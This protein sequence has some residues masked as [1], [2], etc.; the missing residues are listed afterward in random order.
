MGVRRVLPSQNSR[1][2][3][4]AALSNRRNALLAKGVENLKGRIERMQKG[5]NP[6]FGDITW[7]AGGSTSE[8]TLELSK[9]MQ[10]DYGLVT[11]M[12]LTC[13]NMPAEAVHT[14]LEEAKAAGIRNI[15]ALRGDPPNGL[16]GEWTAVTGGFACAL[17]LVKFIRKE[18][19]DFFNITVAG[20]P[21]GHPNALSSVEDDEVLS[22][23]EERRVASVVGPDGERT[24]WVCRD[25]AYAKEMAYLKAKVDAGADCV[26]TQMFLDPETFVDFQTNCRE[27]G[28]NVPIVP[29][30]MCLNAYGGFCRMTSACKTRVPEVARV[31]SL[32]C[33]SRALGNPLKSCENIC[34]AGAAPE[35]GRS[36]G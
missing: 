33:C 26:F 34:P 13:T 11:N 19:G 3:S 28:I 36:Q 2:Q 10:D 12:H 23:A 14:A 22:E 4:S 1:E 35:T 25:D 9:A 6:V 30:V 16:D 27:A 21:E 17:D 29:G 5:L 32:R 18:H 8:L 31:S 20:Y 15:V 7:G 24:R